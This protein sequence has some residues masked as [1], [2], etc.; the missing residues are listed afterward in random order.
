MTHV[1]DCDKTP[2][3]PGKMIAICGATVSIR[4]AVTMFA[5]CPNCDSLNLGWLETLPVL[6][7]SMEQVVRL[8]IDRWAFIKAHRALARKRWRR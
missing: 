5:S 3:R 8:M 1:P 7:N 4:K 2:G 6:F